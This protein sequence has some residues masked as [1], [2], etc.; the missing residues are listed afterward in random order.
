MHPDYQVYFRVYYLTM[1]SLA[2]TIQE[3]VCSTGE[4]MLT[5]EAE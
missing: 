4:M 3:S 5:K 1:P 2:K